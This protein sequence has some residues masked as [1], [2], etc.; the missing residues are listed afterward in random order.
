[1]RVPDI[2]RP[3]AACCDVKGKQPK[4]RHAA[5]LGDMLYQ[6]QLDIPAHADATLA[7]PLAKREVPAWHTPAGNGAAICGLLATLPR[8]PDSTDGLSLLALVVEAIPTPVEPETR[9]DKRILPRITV[10][11][12]PER[13]VGMLF[14]GLH[15]GRQVQAPE[16]PLW[17]G[18]I[19]LKRVPILDL[20]DAAGLP[21]MVQGRGAPL[22]L[23]LFIRA[24][25]TAWT[26]GQASGSVRMQ[27]K[28]RELRDGLYPNGWERR[29]DWPALYRALIHARDYA[30]HDG[31]GRWFPLALRYLP[32]DPSLD[33][34]IALDI[35][36]PP[37]STSGPT[38]NLPAMD[39]P[40]VQSA[41]RWR[42]YIA[43]HTLAWIPGTTRVRHPRSGRWLWTRNIDAYPILTIEDRRRLAFGVSD[44]KHRTTA[45]INA[46]FRDLPGL[47]LVAEDAVD[48]R[49]G[50]VGWRL[51]PAEAAKALTGE[52]EGANRGK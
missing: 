5:R 34:L 14:G 43:S 8:A 2:K 40:S 52:S 16:L 25:A 50:E 37:G 20:V 44:R 1:M 48:Q 45:D 41:S 28:L 36:Y 35:A 27:L 10:S 13:E 46:A 51:V 49:T 12:K 33:D 47:V 3:G 11:E 24:L 30:I 26:A 6:R 18:P 31:R 19:A 39:Q 7:A 42:S 29:R 23:R 4:A 15:E 17:K 9:K 21:V 32:D 22:P 38:V